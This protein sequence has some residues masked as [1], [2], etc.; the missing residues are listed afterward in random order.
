M[1]FPLP[2]QHLYL[3]GDPGKNYVR[4]MRSLAEAGFGNLRRLIAFS[5]IMS[6]EKNK[7]HDPW[8]PSKLQT[9][10]LIVLS[11]QDSIQGFKPISL[12]WIALP[13]EFSLTNGNKLVL[14]DPYAHSIKFI[15]S[16]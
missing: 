4:D 7:F 12:A 2:P 3:F 6:K 9:P 11:K 10:S 16:Q 1:G 14:I 15:L 8:F 5:D 13:R